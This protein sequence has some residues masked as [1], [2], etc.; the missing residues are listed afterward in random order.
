MTAIMK[1]LKNMPPTLYKYCGVRNGRIDWIKRYLLGSEL[2]FS[3]MTSFND[4]LD[5]RIPM[6]FDA[7]PEIAVEYWNKIAPQAAPGEGPEERK[8]HIA[9]LIQNAKTEAG[10]KKLAKYI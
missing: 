8:R 2:Y 1:A 6:S 10:R 3:P 4:P 5:C 7:S 9:E